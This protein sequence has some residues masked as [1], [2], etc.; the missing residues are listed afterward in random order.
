MTKAGV[1]AE[2]AK[3]TGL[4][5]ADARLAVEALTQSIKGVVARGDKVHLRGF[6]SFLTQKRARK[7]ARN[8]S[9]NTA[10]IVEEHYVPSFKPAKAFSKKVKESMNNSI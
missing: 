4:S 8:I 7:I 5:R 9:Q 6:G 3:K 2:I 10:L 1:I